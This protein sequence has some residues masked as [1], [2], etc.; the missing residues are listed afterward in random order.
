[1]ALST[2]IMGQSTVGIGVVVGMTI[3]G[4][5]VIASTGTRE[6]QANR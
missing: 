3:G 2:K 1:M 5:T 4:P 6:Q